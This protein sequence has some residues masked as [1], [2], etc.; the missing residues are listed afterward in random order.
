MDL[1]FNLQ[2]FREQLNELM[3]TMSI[4]H[5]ALWT[6]L[7]ISVFVSFTIGY[8]INKWIAGSTRGFLAT[9][10]G[11]MVPWFVGIGLFV[12]LHM[13]EGLF[14]EYPTWF[15][16]LSILIAT[17][18]FFFTLGIITPLFLGVDFIRGL[19]VFLINCIVITIAVYCVLKWL[20]VKVV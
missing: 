16:Q 13:N 17:A 3:D 14:L 10:T 5:E 1:N 7:G 19:V 6:I 2:S 9:G 4:P 8:L 20:I 12:L 15:L 11:L 18:A